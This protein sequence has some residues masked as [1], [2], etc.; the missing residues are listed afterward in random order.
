MNK[1]LLVKDKSKSICFK[2]KARSHST[3]RMNNLLLLVHRISLCTSK[4]LPINFYDK[5]AHPLDKKNI[6][7]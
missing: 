4:Y 6:K 2:V 1:Y 7:L 3:F 5:D